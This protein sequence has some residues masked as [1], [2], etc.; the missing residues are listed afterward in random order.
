MA[1]PSNDHID[2]DL[3]E[4]QKENIQ[5]LP[6][7]RSAKAL[8]AVFS[9]RPLNE[10]SRSSELDETRTLNDAIRREYEVELDAIAESD[11]P[12]D[13]YDRYVKWTLD[14]YPSAQAT[15]QSGLLPLLERATNAFLS[16]THYKN[17]PRY[18]RLWLHYI[19]LFSDSPRETFAFL[20]RHGVGENLALFYEEFASWLERDG[21]V[22][23]AEEVYKMGIE[24]EARPI[25]RLFRK[26]REFQKRLEQRPSGSEGP[27][28]PALPAVRPALAAKFDPFASSTTGQ[29]AQ[30]ATTN[31][32]LGG[33]GNVSR[34]GKPKMAI[35]SDANGSDESPGT[36]ASPGTKGWESIGSIKD[37]KKENTIEPTPWAGQTL[38]AGKK[39]VATQKMA[40]F[41]DE[42]IQAIHVSQNTKERV[43]PRT[44]KIERVVVNLEAIYP[45]PNNPS[46][47][48]SLDELRA[49]SR[50][51]MNKDWSRQR[52]G[53]LREIPQNAVSCKDSAMNENDCGSDK[54]LSTALQEKLQINDEAQREIS[55]D[56]KGGKVKKL[57]VK[58]VKGET[59]IVKT[60]LDSPTGPKIKRK[61]SS[62]PTMTFHTKAA[63]DE[64]YGI[65]NQP[66]K[67]ELELAKDLD[68]VYGSDYEDDDCTSAG[69]STATGGISAP[70]SEFGDEETS[71]FEATRASIG[72]LGE[73]T[74]SG[75]TNISEW[76]E[77]SPEQHIPRV[78]TI[79]PRDEEDSENR[80]GLGMLPTPRQGNPFAQQDE[81]FVLVPPED[82]NPP[83]GPYRDA[84]VAAQNRLPFM[85]PIVEHTESSLAS[86]MFK[87]KQYMSSKTPSKGSK[88]LISA[89]TPAI[90]EMDDLL[91][92]SPFRDFADKND[93]DFEYP[94]DDGSPS[95]L[96]GKFKSPRNS[97]K[98]GLPQTRVIIEDAQCNPI[99][100]SVRERVLKDICPPLRAYPGYH[101]HTTQLGGNAVEIK[102][103]IKALA[104]S[105]KANGG[106]KQFTIPP[107]IC[108]SG[109]A[110]SYA[111]KRELGEGGFAPVYLAES[112]DSPDTFSDSEQENGPPAVN[113]TS[114]W[115][116]GNSSTIRDL[117]RKPLEALKV[118][119][120]PPS[121]WEFYMLQTARGRIENSLDYRRAKD[122]I[123]Q[124]HEMHV[125]KDESILVEDYLNQGTLLDLI[126]VRTESCGGVA[127]SDQ[128]L[129]EV[130]IMFFAVELFRTVEA[131]HSC[132]ILHGDLKPD[133]CLVRLNEPTS[134]AAITTPRGGSLLDDDDGVHSA[135]GNIEYSPSGLYGWKEKG[136]TLIDFGRGIDMCVFN[137]DV[138]FIADW[139]IGQ[140]ECTEMREC[141]PWTYQVDLYGL[142]G[143]IYVMLFGK[144]MEVSQVTERSSNGSGSPSVV[145]NGPGL[146]AQKIYRIK[147]SLKRYWE[148]DIWSD[149]FDLCLNPLSSRWMEIECNTRARTLP[150]TETGD[151]LPTFPVV[152]SMRI[153][154]EKM[155]AWLV[156]NAGR[157]GLQNHLDNLEMLIARKRGKRDV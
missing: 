64:I 13:I 28:S 43:D 6:S 4:T 30:A 5:S 95:K 117:Y 77:F 149:V 56:Q 155:E 102:K 126:N 153:V 32:G 128:G 136:L 88:F 34:S 45:D 79:T 152:H 68:S 20:A 99:E 35:F 109:A 33:S 36:S 112:V 84:F 97:I 9:P 108:L 1:R 120:D 125:F 19:Q 110:R 40:V 135:D 54:Y 144:Y 65:F 113:K 39:P 105:S 71:A 122:S 130:V 14:A 78:G 41:K 66:L 59:Q 81:N 72:G 142:A 50:G 31:R 141:R 157:K 37:R 121:A 106:E 150:C 49:T 16:S 67:S 52:K 156:A 42:P 94:L 80:D 140:H 119:S 86:T 133:N 96:V 92:E 129:D 87:N 101:D 11:D 23:Q 143:T 21:R 151:K 82:Y 70:G 139:K 60:N 85:T 147:E 89:T 63:T 53:P 3:I 15:S 154:R 17:D 134:A 118:E 124:C 8:A 22:S 146:G 26:F 46:L 25:E 104:R 58:E 47:E 69:E 76:T 62:E 27:S 83:T 137:P 127:P 114:S 148:R 145:N 48:L 38:K 2:F 12:L 93:T 123:V 103:Y 75:V 107:I 55:R 44:G 74:E 61:G 115:A 90:P 98:R 138:Q 10:S 100:L 131:L 7:G 73:Q 116:C 29:G 24:K 91:L 18:L 57:K 51:W 111:V 132:G